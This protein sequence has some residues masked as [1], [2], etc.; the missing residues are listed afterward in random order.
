MAP[1]KR[2]SFTRSYVSEV[3]NQARVVV[4]R[5]TQEQV[6]GMGPVLRG[7]WATHEMN[8]IVDAVANAQKKEQEASDIREWMKRP[9][10]KGNGFA[11]C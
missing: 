11:A 10:P 7:Q 3:D 5:K 6:D 8:S 9:S 2:K 1:K 4:A